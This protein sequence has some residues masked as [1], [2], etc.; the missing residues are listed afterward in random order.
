MV[1]F[2]IT[3]LCNLTCQY[4]YYHGPGST[5]VKSG[6]NFMPYE[7]FERLS[8]ECK[9]LQVDTIY[10][11]GQGEPTL[12]PR[13]YDMLRHLEP[14]FSINL[15][16]N[17]TF[18]IERCR[19]ILRADHIVINM[20]EADRESYRALMGKDL[21]VKVI[22]NIRELARLRS[23]YNPNFCIEVL[24]V[25]TRLNAQNLLKTEN[26]VRKIGANVVQ[27]R[28]LEVSEQ[29]RHIQLQQHQDKAEI[30]G[31]WPPCFHGWFN[32]AIKFN[33][34][35]NVCCFMQAVK[36]GNAYESGFKAVWESASYTQARALALNGGEPFRTY[37]HCINC[38]VAWRN[39]E[40]AGQ[41]EAYQR[42]RNA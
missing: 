27:K 11:S 4:C 3:E 40:I 42:V 29:N 33:G 30:S 41:M 26:L 25:M 22:K 17:G 38:R 19:D 31:E 2:H 24:L 36:V 21:F 15:I 18:P 23:L 12:H 8:L 35:V 13:F 1:Q 9:E 6:E 16:S 37:H 28:V 20:G 32:S 10:L 39:R 34:D 7:L 5:H 14:D